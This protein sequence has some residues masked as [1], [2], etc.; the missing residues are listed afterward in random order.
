VDEPA[1]CKSNFWLNAIML[2]DADIRD[3][4]LD[5]SNGAGI[6][7]RPIWR[8]MSELDMYS[9][10]QCGPLENSQWLEKRVVNLPSSTRKND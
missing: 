7:T 3:V 10:C 1:G 6:M 5:A 8:L 4:F 9:H 2:A